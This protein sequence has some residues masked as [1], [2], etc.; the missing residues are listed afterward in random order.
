VRRKLMLVALVVCLFASLTTV[1]LATTTT[2]RGP[3]YWDCTCLDGSS[4][5]SQQWRETWFIKSTSGTSDTAI[6]FIDSGAYGY[7]WH[8]TVRNTASFQRAYAYTSITTPYVKKAYCKWYSG[9]PFN[10]SCT[11][12]GP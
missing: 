8:G 10:G 9:T 6:T 12:Y 4:S 2:Y 11:V 7:S 5:Y 1:A 3:M